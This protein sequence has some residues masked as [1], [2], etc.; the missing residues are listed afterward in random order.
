MKQLNKRQ[1]DILTLAEKEGYV[2]VDNLAQTFEVTQQTIRR[3]MGYLSDHELLVR[4]HGG[5]FFASGVKN[6]AYKSRKDLA[7]D[8]KR[9][10]ANVVAEI[11]PN[12]SSIILN[13]GTTTERV[14]EALLDHKE[15]KVITNNINIVNIF[16]HSNDAQVWLAGGK[17][18]K[19]DSAIIGENTANYFKEFK[20]DYAIVGISAIDN[21]GSLMDFDRRESTVSKAIFENSRKLILVADDIKFQRTAPMITGNISEVD[22]LVTNNKPPPE[23]IDICNSNNIDIVIA[24]E[25]T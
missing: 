1:E 18:R 12:N 23:I 25:N 11:I 9:E 6:F 4:T 17:V 16:S 10:I 13:I 8:E 15:L 22:I 14:A 20:V 3:D 19:S 21:D 7:S 24:K 2:S 5:A